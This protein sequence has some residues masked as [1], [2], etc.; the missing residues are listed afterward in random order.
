MTTGPAAR[1]AILG[2]FRS[3]PVLPTR[4]GRSAGGFR[5]E[6]FVFHF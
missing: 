5:D 2:P 4:R 3:F 6:K 1:T